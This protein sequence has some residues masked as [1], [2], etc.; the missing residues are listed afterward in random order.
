MSFGSSG[1]WLLTG[2]CSL[3]GAQGRLW[4]PGFS[5]QELLFSQSAGSRAQGR[6]RPWLQVQSAGSR[7]LAHRLS[8]A[9]TCRAFLAERA[10][11]RTAHCKADSYLLDRQGSPTSTLV[12]NVS[13]TRWISCL[14]HSSV[15]RDGMYLRV[16]TLNIQFSSVQSLSRVQ[17]FATPWTAARQASLP[18]SNSRN[19]LQLTSIELAMLSN[20]LILSRPFLLPPSIF[21]SIRVFSDEGLQ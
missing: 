6:Q 8:C 17:F 12:N 18:I 1:S 3:W 14:I 9:H 11:Q 4:L 10:D 20:H 15:K 19:L 16:V 21:P 2:A 5:W 7:V 13:K